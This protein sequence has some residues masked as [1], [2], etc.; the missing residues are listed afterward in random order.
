MMVADDDL[1]TV[2]TRF[3]RGIQFPV[4]PVISATSDTEYWIARLNRAMTAT[5]A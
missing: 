4:T 5:N 2:M 3:K 1:S